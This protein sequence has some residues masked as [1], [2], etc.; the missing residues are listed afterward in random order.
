MRGSGT[1]PPLTYLS[2]EQSGDN[3][4]GT[5]CHIQSGG[6][7]VYTVAP[8]SGRYPNVMFVVT[9]ASGCN[10]PLCEGVLGTR[11][12]GTVDGSGEIISMTSTGP[13]GLR[14]KRIEQISSTCLPSLSP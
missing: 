7:V 9:E 11:W 8:V 13:D 10:Q 1:S 12:T 2:L 6:R 4:T 3:I 14:F 5:A